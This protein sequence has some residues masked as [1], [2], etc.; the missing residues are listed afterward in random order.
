MG[1][2]RGHARA[3]PVII[4]FHV[5]HT[6][7]IIAFL[8]L[9]LHSL[10]A[11]DMTRFVTIDDVL[12]TRPA[13]LELSL[14]SAD[15]TGLDHEQ[16]R[17]TSVVSARAASA[18]LCTYAGQDQSGRRI[19]ATV[20]RMQ[21]F[22]VTVIE[23]GVGYDLRQ[24]PGETMLRRVPAPSQETTCRTAPELVSPQIRK[25][26][27]SS[28]K[29]VDHVQSD[30]TLTLDVAIECDG[31]LVRELGSIEAAR[32]YVTHLIAVGSAVYEQELRVR[33]RIANLRIWT[34]E[35]SPY[36]YEASVGELLGDFVQLYDSTM[37]DIERDIAVFITSRTSGQG[38]ARSIGGLCEKG[39][40]YCAIDIK[41]SV[42][43][44]PT[45][46]W[47]ASV[48]CHEIGHVCGGIHTQSCFWPQPLDSCIASESG[49]CYSSEEVRPTRGTIMSYCHMQQNNGGTVVLEFHPR[50]RP[51][52]RAY[53]EQAQCLGSP[54][55]RRD[56]SAL[57]VIVR[58]R[59]GRPLQGVQLSL[60]PIDDDLYGGLPKPPKQPIKLS[61]ANGRVRFDSLG[62][63]LYT[64]DIAKPFIRIGIDEFEDDA[65][66]TT[67]VESSESQ[68]ILTLSKSVLTRFI[69]D[70][71]NN[72]NTVVLS[73]FMSSPE[74]RLELDNCPT[75]TQAST[76]IYERYIVPGAYVVVPSAIGW[77]FMPQSRQHTID[78]DSAI[79][80][81]Q[82]TG[83]KTSDS[84]M[85]IAIGA[86]F[87]NRTSAPWQGLVG[88]DEY[89]LYDD[90]A[91]DIVAADVV[92]ENGVAIIEN[93]PA[94][95]VYSA[96]TN[97]DT[98]QY[99]RWYQVHNAVVPI[100]GV[101][102]TLFVKRE[103]KRPLFARPYI[104]SRSIGT[105]KPLFEPVFLQNNAKPRNVI[106]QIE[107][108][109][110]LPTGGRTISVYRNGF[111][112]FGTNRLPLYTILPLQMTDDVDAIVSP[113]G[114]FIVPDI[115]AP[116]PWHVAYEIQGVAPNR[117]AVIEWQ[118]LAAR[119]FNFQGIATT[120][121]R[122]TFQVR[123]HENSTIEFV[124][125]RP[126]A[127]LLPTSAHI[128]LRGADELDNSIVRF[129][130][131]SASNAT[132]GFEFETN[133]RNVIYETDMPSGLTY[134]WSRG[135]TSVASD[136]R[137]SVTAATLGNKIQLRSASLM[138][139]VHVYSL[140]GALVVDMPSNSEFA[141]LSCD[142]LASGPYTVVVTT[143][144]ACY[145]KTI[146][147]LAR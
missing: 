128:G 45:W 140:H 95:R 29:Q 6:Y 146:M 69:I 28:R 71:V 133:P 36:D 19:I 32:A 103:R 82:F 102:S 93:M 88:G 135:A 108:P 81:L 70:S 126:V 56:T 59:Q 54:G 83:V 47:D 67:M 142:G 79:V 23:N 41:A 37:N 77:R 2:P 63:A 138:R 60:S 91:G 109:F 110:E 117:V 9:C 16:L 55:R 145:V 8:L 122:F 49:V 26:V 65:S 48:L 114:M 96:W 94:E 11:Q 50:Q 119:V 139:R 17:K 132:A 136:E 105:Y 121:G 51:I 143:D 53:I 101:P 33:L 39:A 144:D 40:S 46:S 43:D 116:N 118:E 84:Q 30:D 124:Y 78:P 106:S 89:R 92:P 72:G 10:Q 73:R 7:T 141:E 5:K 20:D 42:E 24:L 112:T 66:V 44:Y 104:F 52:L 147:H 107:T 34:P 123:I 130:S 80:T 120:S 21:G 61:D 38:I 99:A 27:A 64:I 18:A 111:L 57:T 74:V 127:L 129:Q 75:S 62:V 22:L 137:E 76:S 100:Y 35:D 12:R 115:N 113:L 15:G 4:A 90:D 58:D 3:K 14:P 86:G 25:M 98:A 87:V 85:T 131:N 13:L 125:Q 31:D 97:I 68:S 134:R 1:T